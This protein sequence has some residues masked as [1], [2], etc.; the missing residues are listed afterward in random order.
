MARESTI[1]IL[2]GGTTTGAP[3]D[4]SDGELAYAHGS[5]NLFVGAGGNNTAVWVGAEI[6]DEANL[7]SN[8]STAL[9]TQQSIKTYVDNSIGASAGVTSIETLTGTVNVTTSDGIR[10]TVSGG[11]LAFAG[12]TASDVVKGVA[13]F[14]ATHFNVTSGGQVRITSNAIGASELANNSVDTDSIQ[15]G[16]VTNAKLENSTVGVVAGNGLS[17]TL[18]NIGLGLTGTLSVNVD[19]STIAIVGDTLRVRGGGITNTELEKSYV[20]YVDGDSVTGTPTIELGATLD[21]AGTDGLR[22][23]ISVPVGQPPKITVGIDNAGIAN[24]K[25]ANSKIVVTDGST[26]SDIN[27]GDTLT[28]QGTANEV[29]VSQSAGTYTIGLPDNVTIAGNLT[30]NGTVTTIDVATVEVED[31]IL[32][33]ARGNTGGDSVDIGFYGTYNDGDQ[34]YSGLVRNPSLSDSSGNAEFVFFTDSLIEPTTT[35]SDSA[36]LATIRAKIKA[37]TYS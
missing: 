28:V 32:K 20:F 22:T 7:D 11:D 33:L 36:T 35:I 21:T 9:A 2:Y 6:L 17:S 3:T 8:S 16:A 24:A 1:Q 10:H 14:Y 31:P 4:L 18:E 5:K 26:P 27:L 12:V 13:S 37:G 15:T 30:V 25:L 29:E 34:K 19:N 23:T